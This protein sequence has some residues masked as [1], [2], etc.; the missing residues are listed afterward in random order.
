MR[1]AVVE[2]ATPIAA[3]QESDEVI[4]LI[5]KLRWIGLE[6]QAKELRTALEQ[7]PSPRRG[8][9]VAGPHSTD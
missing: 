9:L 2:P 7:C 1:W 4:K 5:R 8:T 3:E 6:A